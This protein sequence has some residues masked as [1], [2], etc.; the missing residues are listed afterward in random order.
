MQPILTGLTIVLILAGAFIAKDSVRLETIVL[1]SL[2]LL[3][4]GVAVRQ[5]FK[6]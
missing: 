4:I 5:R 3:L 1:S 2:G 6:R